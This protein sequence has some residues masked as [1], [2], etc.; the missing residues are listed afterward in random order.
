MLHP[1][2]PAALGAH[3]VP[4]GRTF[5]LQHVF[6][7]RSTEQ[8]VTDATTDPT[9]T[10][11]ELAAQQAPKG[12]PTPSRREAEAAR[13]A[14]L[15]ALPTDPKARRKVERSQQRESYA[16]ERQAVRSGDTPVVV[17]S[18]LT[19]LLH[20]TTLYIDASFVM[21]GVVALGIGLSVVLNLRVKKAVREQF[22]PD[23]ARGAGFY[24]FSRA[25]MPRPMRQPK[26]LFTFNGE[27]K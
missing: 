10:A 24:A 17:L 27:P 16:R 21:E 15:G 25:L 6:L 13:K 4:A 26:P 20:D 2:K 1:G 8:A 11:A 19:I 22:G 14:R 23:A 7:R 9:A 5:T 12:R 3:F 18:W